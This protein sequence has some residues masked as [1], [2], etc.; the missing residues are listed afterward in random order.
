MHPGEQ[1]RCPYTLAPAAGPSSQVSRKEERDTAQ[2]PNRIVYRTR[3]G[4]FARIG[5]CDI[6]QLPGIPPETDIPGF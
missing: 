5:Q 4:H 6:H 1:P 3:Y 2:D